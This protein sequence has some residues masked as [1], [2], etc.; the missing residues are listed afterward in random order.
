MKPFKKDVKGANIIGEIL[1]NK[2]LQYTIAQIDLI[3][4]AT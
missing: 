1:T 4:D 3:L 2:Y